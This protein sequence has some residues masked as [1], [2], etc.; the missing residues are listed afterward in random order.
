MYPL[1]TLCS[2]II[3]WYQGGA[4]RP[5]KLLPGASRIATE[6]WTSTP[7]IVMTHHLRNAQRICSGLGLRNKFHGPR[8]TLPANNFATLSTSPHPRD[9]H[10]HIEH[11]SKIVWGD[12]KWKPDPRLSRKSWHEIRLPQLLPYDG[13]ASGGWGQVARR[14]MPRAGTILT[15]GN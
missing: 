13:Q 10:L 9:N 7:Q 5:Q 15:L 4:I 1:F 11:K 14:G 2:K 6:I 3:G 12:L 8:I